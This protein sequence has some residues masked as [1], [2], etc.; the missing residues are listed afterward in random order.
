MDENVCESCNGN[1]ELDNS[2]NCVCP[3]D[4][5]DTNEDTCCYKQCLTCFDG[6]HSSCLTC[7]EINYFRTL[8]EGSCICM[9]GYYEI[10]DLAC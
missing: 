1:R 6:G 10:G 8:Y 2:L 3:V 4:T 5:I 7:D 9:E